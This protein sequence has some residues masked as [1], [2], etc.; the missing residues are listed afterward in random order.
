MTNHLNR[1]LLLPLGKQELATQEVVQIKP[2]A[3]RPTF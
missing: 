3:F 1:Y 2:I